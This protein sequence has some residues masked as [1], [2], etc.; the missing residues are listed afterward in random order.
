M[1]REPKCEICSWS[2]VNPISKKQAVQIDHIDGNSRNN[3]ISNLRIICPNCHS[4][5]PT[6]AVLNKGNGDP[7][8]RKN[9]IKLGRAKHLRGLKDR[10]D[11]LKKSKIAT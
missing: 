7:D 6:Y 2:G 9:Y 3:H 1:F 10:Y 11:A 4:L 8:R 5:T